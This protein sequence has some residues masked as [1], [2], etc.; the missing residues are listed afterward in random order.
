MNC[1]TSPFEERIRYRGLCLLLLVGLL[2]QTCTPEQDHPVWDAD[3]VS[4]VSKRRSGVRYRSAIAHRLHI[5]KRRGLVMLCRMGLMSVL[6]VWSGWG[7]HWPRSW[8]LLSLPLMDALLSILPLY[9]P[10]VLKVRAYPYVVR[11]RYCPLQVRVILSHPEEQT[12]NHL[13][14]EKPLRALTGVSAAAEK[15]VSFRI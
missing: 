7:Q 2:V 5:V 8:L 11:G 6:L 1:T 4:W 14:R 15:A 10:Q 12:N 13:P 9:W 3:L